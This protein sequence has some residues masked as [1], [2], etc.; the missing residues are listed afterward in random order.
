MHCLRTLPILA[1]LAL[2]IGVVQQ[3][4]LRAQ[5]KTLRWGGDKAGGAPFIY[6]EEGKGTV[7]FEW[8]ISKYLADQIKRKPVFVQVDWDNLPETLERGDI[9]V[10]MN[11]M[12]YR[13]EWEEKYPA[14]LPYFIFSL[15]L[16]V[17]ADDKVIRTWNDLRV[18]EGKPKIRVGVLRGSL[19]ERYLEKK[20]GDNITLVP[21]KEVD[22]TFQLVEDGQRLDATVQDS[23]AAL[24]YVQSGRLPKLKVV[25]EPVGRG[26]YVLLT[27]K[28][29]KPQEVQDAKKLREQLN[30]AIR[31]GFTSGTFEEIYRRYG[32][33]DSEQERLAYIHLNWQKGPER[34]MAE[35]STAEEKEEA[36]EKPA[37]PVVAKRSIFSLQDK[38]LEAAWMTVKLAFMSMPIAIIIGIL[39]A[40]SRLYGPGILR[41]PMTI[42]VE[43]IRGTPLILQMYVWFFLVPQVAKMSGWD[44]LIWITNLPP[45]VV[46]VFALAINYSAYEA[47]IFRAGLQA[48]PRG[49]MEAA[50]ALGMSPLTA[51]RRILLPQAIRIVIPPVTNDFIALF[52]DT[53]I[54]SMIL[55][56]ELTCLYYQ[57]K[58]DRD[59]VLQLAFVIGSIYL[60]MSYPLSR[61]SIWLEGRL[62]RNRG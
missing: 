29:A 44:S 55:I 14:T 18:P 26:F 49:Q 37:A 60:L 10:A 38:I 22:E 12:E 52:K 46:G 54:C 35:E 9:D 34:R 45:I 1:A 21:T 28:G 47:E 31:L 4:S 50:L 58:Y 8:E 11:G 53:S 27:P 2:L 48:I 19:A 15:R 17:K 16:I 13:T 7:G 23:P 56:T 24:Y 32:L 41:I 39:I 3:S 25:A 30:D 36:G 61:L 59:L 57:N 5:E 51:I 6:E 33:W 20:F 62:R 42:Y 43:V 40:V